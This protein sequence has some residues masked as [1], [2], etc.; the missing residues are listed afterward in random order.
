MACRA[1]S[2]TRTWLQECSFHSGESQ[3]RDSPRFACKCDVYSHSLDQACVA[4]D[5]GLCGGCG[6][7]CGYIARLP[8]FICVASV[9]RILLQEQM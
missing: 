7:C 2:W 9:L 8:L 5:F 1:V 3:I 6:C 4:V